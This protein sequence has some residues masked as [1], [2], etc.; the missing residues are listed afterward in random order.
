MTLF[1]VRINYDRDMKTLTEVC[2]GVSKK[3]WY[4]NPG[5]LR[6][7]LEIVPY[8]Q[9][10]K[11]KY[12]LIFLKVHCDISGAPKAVRQNRILSDN[13]LEEEEEGEGDQQEEDEDEDEGGELV[14]EEDQLDEEDG[15]SRSSSIN[16][17]PPPMSH[18]EAVELPKS[19]YRLVNIT[20]SQVGLIGGE[21]VCVSY[22][23]QRFWVLK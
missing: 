9:N 2:E 23:K 11:L 13:S 22:I 4:G 1:T 19:R 15:S 14:V 18:S 20:F 5:L 6:S 16:I 21:Y 17:T 12:N 7:R 3:A 10:R 8:F